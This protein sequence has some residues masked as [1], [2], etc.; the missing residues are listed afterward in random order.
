MADTSLI[1]IP[2]RDN[3]GPEHWQTLWESK[4]FGCVR[5]AQRDW[6]APRREAWVA[7]LHE[8]IAAQPGPVIL[9]A[10]SLGCITVAHWAAEHGAPPAAVGRARKGP[11]AG[12]VVAALLVAPPDLARPGADP[13]MVGSF[14]PVPRARLP[15]R[16]VMVASTNDPYGSIG[17]AR[18]LAQAWGS[19][20]VDVGGLGHINADS[21]LRDWPQGQS[22]LRKLM[23]GRPV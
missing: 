22:L 16:S 4:F 23:L 18:E 6:A 21:N 10:H 20:F 2:G 7:G 9:I 19:E 14:L 15:F 1:I 8:T 3:S 11:G 17:V 12:D 13:A 5:V